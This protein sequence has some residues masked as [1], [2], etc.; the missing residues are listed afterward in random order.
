M[1]TRVSA[2]LTGLDQALDQLTDTAISLHRG[3][4]R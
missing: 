2:I 4:G 1:T 3:S